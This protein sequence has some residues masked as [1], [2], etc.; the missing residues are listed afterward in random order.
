MRST[1]KLVVVTAIAA[2]SLMVTLSGGQVLTQ[3]CPDG[4]LLQEYPGR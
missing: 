3:E 1:P 2:S 4:D